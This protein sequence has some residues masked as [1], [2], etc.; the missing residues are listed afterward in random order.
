MIFGLFDFKFFSLKFV[1]LEQV[2]VKV[3]LE[4]LL[5]GPYPLVLFPQFISELLERLVLLVGREGLIFKVS[6]ILVARLLVMMMLRLSHVLLLGH[7]YVVL[8]CP[9]W[10]QIVLLLFIMPSS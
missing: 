8:T 1:D 3:L 7:H 9:S 5:L 10:V 4:S 2:G 6:L